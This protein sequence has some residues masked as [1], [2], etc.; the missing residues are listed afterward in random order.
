MEKV[1][2]D[3]QRKMVTENIFGLKIYFS[4]ILQYT[5][6]FNVV[7]K[8]VLMKIKYTVLDSHLFLRDLRKFKNKARVA[9]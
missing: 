6:I 8:Q 5:S 2:F 7:T 9:I 4:V 1:L 3:S